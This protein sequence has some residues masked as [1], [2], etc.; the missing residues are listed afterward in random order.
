MIRGAANVHGLYLAIGMLAVCSGAS[1][2]FYSIFA[3]NSEN[4]MPTGYRPND[5][6]VLT[7]QVEAPSKQSKFQI[8]IRKPDGPPR[9]DLGMIDSNGEPVTGACST[10]HTTRPADQANRSVADLTEFHQELTFTHGNVSCLSCHNPENYD[11][12]RLADGSAVEYAEVMTLCAQCHGPQTR[13]Y[14]HGAH[15]GMNGYWDLSL[16]P[17]TRNNCVDCH[18]PHAPSFP[19]MQPTFKPRDRFLTADDE[20]GTKSHE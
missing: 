19:A 6:A 20:I 9:I 18:A 2:V 12:L 3:A 8:I 15:G 7:E 1:W 10:C 5:S 11:T 17:R 16:G 4:E 13:D 14:H